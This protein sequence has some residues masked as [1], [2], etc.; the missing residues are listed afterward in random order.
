MLVLAFLI[1]IQVYGTPKWITNWLKPFHKIMLKEV[2]CSFIRTKIW[3]LVQSFTGIWHDNLKISTLLLVRDYIFFSF[4]KKNET[5]IHLNAV[6]SERNISLTWP[7][8]NLTNFIILFIISNRIIKINKLL[9]CVHKS[10]GLNIRV[11][12]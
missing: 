5:P 2:C 10:N 7:E 9:K 4:E 6:R 8:R 3:F 11:L 12:A 1:L